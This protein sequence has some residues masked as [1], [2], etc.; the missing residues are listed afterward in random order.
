MAVFAWFIVS[1]E[2]CELIVVRSIR[3]FLSCVMRA[4]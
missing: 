4:N 3:W 2:Q 1:G